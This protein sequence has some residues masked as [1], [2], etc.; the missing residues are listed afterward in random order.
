MT[1]PYSSDRFD[2][3]FRGIADG[4]IPALYLKAIYRRR[5]RGGRRDIIR[6]PQEP[7][8]IEV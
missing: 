4:N 7:V 1:N 5:D 2:I 6:C 8:L 3:N